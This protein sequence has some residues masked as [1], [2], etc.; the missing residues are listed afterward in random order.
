[1]LRLQNRREPLVTNGF[2]Y[3][4]RWLGNLVVRL[5]ADWPMRGAN[6]GGCICGHRCVRRGERRHG[7]VYQ[8][9]GV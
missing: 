2:Y 1:M 9:E 6:E 5:G 8:P 4:K 3:P 7:C